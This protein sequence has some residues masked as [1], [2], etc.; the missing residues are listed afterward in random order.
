MSFCCRIRIRKHLEAYQT[1]KMEEN[2][3]AN[4]ARRQDTDRI[5]AQGVLLE[6]QFGCN[7]YGLWKHIDTVNL[8]ALRG[9][10]LA[11]M[12]N[13][14][15]AKGKK[16]SITLKGKFP[17]PEHCGGHAA[18]GWELSVEQEV[19]DQSEYGGGDLKYRSMSLLL[20]TPAGMLRISEGMYDDR[21]EG[22]IYGG[23][24][25]QFSYTETL[26]DIPTLP[27]PYDVRDDPGPGEEFPKEF[28]FKQFH[29]LRPFKER[30]EAS[31]DG[32][33]R[34]KALSED[35]WQHLCTL[36]SDYTHEMED[37][38]F[39]AGNVADALKKI[40]SLADKVVHCE[41]DGAKLDQEGKYAALISFLGAWGWRE[42]PGC[43]GKDISDGP[44]VHSCELAVVKRQDSIGKTPMRNRPTNLKTTDVFINPSVLDGTKVEAHHFGQ[45]PGWVFARAV[46]SSD[47]TVVVP[48]FWSDAAGLR[49]WLKLKNVQPVI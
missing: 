42:F 29:D 49:G 47:G 45:C 20:F 24:I 13:A 32:K 6:K 39:Q 26:S 38:V 33:I 37:F 11:Q 23:N 48:C 9:Y 35:R 10:M 19:I 30:I 18:A 2:I 5:F 8:A 44:T 14:S 40:A 17:N 3:E 36:G 12:D 16:F 22:D 1:P 27:E 43:R 15:C 7:P 34:A 41:F 31:E 28:D 4:S 21:Q 25:L 46:C